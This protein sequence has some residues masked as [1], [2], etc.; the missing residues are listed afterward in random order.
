MHARRKS[1]LIV[2]SFAMLLA[3]DAIASAAPRK[4]SVVLG[5]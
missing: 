3:A 1:F 2:L 4:H 5:A